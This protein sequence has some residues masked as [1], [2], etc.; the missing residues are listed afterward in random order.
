MAFLAVTLPLLHK[1]LCASPIYEVI[2][3]I[4]QP[5]HLIKV[6]R[7]ENF[8]SDYPPK[9]GQTARMTIFSA[10]N[11]QP[12]SRQSQVFYRARSPAATLSLYAIP[13]TDA[14][15]GFWP[16]TSKLLELQKF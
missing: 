6:R 16:I 11:I 2:F 3:K 5:F 13:I 7:T 4:W 1:F 8:T 12:F 9:C 15:R 14:A 10:K